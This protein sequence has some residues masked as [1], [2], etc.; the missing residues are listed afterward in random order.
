[1]LLGSAEQIGSGQVGAMIGARA[2]IAYDATTMAY[3]VAVAWQGVSATF[4][5]AGW[6]SAPDGVRNCAL[7]LYGTDTQRRVVWN[8]VRVASLQ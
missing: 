4:S 2:C 8:V 5:P 1:M 6:T 7:N 3:S